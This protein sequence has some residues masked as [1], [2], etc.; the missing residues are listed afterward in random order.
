MSATD[1]RAQLVAEALYAERA[2]TARLDRRVDD[3]TRHLAAATSAVEDLHT[4]VA[5]WIGDG[6]VAD[7]HALGDLL[8]E[9]AEVHEMLK[10]ARHIG[11]QA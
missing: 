7:H 6:G 9:I 4:R 2:R 10:R 8:A 5:G 1:T 11:A 3:L